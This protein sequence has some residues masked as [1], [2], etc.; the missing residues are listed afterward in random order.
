[1]PES[2]RLDER[3]VLMEERGCYAASADRAIDQ[4]RDHLE[5]VVLTELKT[6]R[7]KHPKRSVAFM[8][9]MGMTMIGVSN[10]PNCEPYSVNDYSERS[11]DDPHHRVFRDLI[12]LMDW[13]IEKSDEIRVSIN[14][15]IL[16]DPIWPIHMDRDEGH[17]RFLEGN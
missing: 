4:L 8:D 6:W 17:S 10:S 9:A 15:I 3:A 13:Y 7:S 14:D 1:M 2:G 11:E 5:Y 16:G 12:D